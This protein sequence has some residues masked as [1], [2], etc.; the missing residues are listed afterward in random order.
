M[1]SDGYTVRGQRLASESQRFPLPYP[2]PMIEFASNPRDFDFW[3]RM[4]YYVYRLPDPASF[5][6]V[7]PFSHDDYVVLTRYLSTCESLA[8]SGFLN[9]VRNYT[10]AQSNGKLSETSFLEGPDE[11]ATRSMS[12]LFRQLY[13]PSELASFNR[14]RNLL[15]KH[16]SARITGSDARGML[17]ILKAWQLA[18]VDLLKAPLPLTTDNAVMAYD[19][20]TPR[21]PVALGDLPTPPELFKVFAYGDLIHWGE[22]R[23]ELATY[24]KNVAWDLLLQVNLLESMLPLSHLYIG[25]GVLVQHAIG[26]RP[27]AEPMRGRGN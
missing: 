9:T 5:P 7:A 8:R 4:L 11:E 20:G 17:D 26:S 23:H 25:F 6:R 19:S 16:V 2:V 15:S 12:V 14:V 3:W 21:Q 1:S 18:Q 10:L 27:R 22:T 13:Q 24:R